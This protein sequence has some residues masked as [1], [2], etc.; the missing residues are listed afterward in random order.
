MAKRTT[1]PASHL[2][3]LIWDARVKVYISKSMLEDDKNWGEFDPDSK[4]I[5]IHPEVVSIKELLDTFCHETL[6]HV[7]PDFNETQIDQC[8]KKVLHSLSAFERVRLVLK[9]A[10]SLQQVDI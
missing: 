2:K 9:L 3:V 1:P 6:H 4:R 8:T 10:Q 7:I 5:V